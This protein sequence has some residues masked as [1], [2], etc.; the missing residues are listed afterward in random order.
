MGNRWTVGCRRKRW[1]PGLGPRL[2]S[3]GPARLR[4]Q[5]G[6]GREPISPYPPTPPAA[7]GQPAR[8]SNPPAASRVV[9]GRNR[10]EER[11]EGPAL[12]DA[13]LRV[14]GLPVAL[15]AGP[16]AAPRWP[17]TRAPSRQGSPR[18]SPGSPGEPAPREAG[19][20]RPSPDRRP[21]R[22]GQCLLIGDGERQSVYLPRYVLPLACPGLSWAQ[23]PCPSSGPSVPPTRSLRSNFQGP[24][25]LPKVSVP[26]S[27]QPNLTFF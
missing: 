22:C 10:E 15:P 17:E 1:R 4:L 16:G 23:V 2:L 18:W 25:I 3:A 12:L 26:S 14:L 9:G 13:V 11:S 21:T 27:P 24:Q 7:E 5:T 8:L 6:R 19:G 20:Q